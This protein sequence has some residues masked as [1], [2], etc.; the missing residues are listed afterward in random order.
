MRSG[1]RRRTFQRTMLSIHFKCSMNC[2]LLLATLT[3]ISTNNAQYSFQMFDELFVAFG[4]SDEH[5]NEH[6]AM[7]RCQPRSKQ[8][9]YADSH[10]FAGFMR[11]IRMEHGNA[12][13]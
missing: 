12:E 13:N 2:S 1:Q 5:F 4:H 9:K 6:F 11:K 7:I 8:L 10:G 3:N